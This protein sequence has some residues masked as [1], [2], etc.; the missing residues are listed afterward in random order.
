MLSCYI[1]ITYNSSDWIANLHRNSRQPYHRVTETSPFTNYTCANIE[2]HPYT[3]TVRVLAWSIVVI[4]L[5]AKK[6]SSQLGLFLC[7]Q[8]LPLHLV[9]LDGIIAPQASRLICV[10]IW[11]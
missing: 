8:H 9:G 5:L 10:A 4:S 2:C 7:A 3:I 11:V 1:Y 6:L